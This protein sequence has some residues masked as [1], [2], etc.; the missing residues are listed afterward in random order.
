MMPARAAP[1]RGVARMAQSLLLDAGGDKPEVVRSLCRTRQDERKYVVAPSLGRTKSH[2]R[3]PHALRPR[4]TMG[5]S[6]GLFAPWAARDCGLSLMA[7][8]QVGRVGVD[9]H[10]AAR[11]IWEAARAEILTRSAMK[12]LG[13]ATQEFFNGNELTPLDLGVRG[14]QFVLVRGA[15]NK[16]LIGTA[17]NDGHDGP[18]GKRYSPNAI[19]PLTTVPVATCMGQWHSSIGARATC[20]GLTGELTGMLQQGAT[21]RMRPCTA[22]GAWQQR[23]RVGRHVR[24][25]LA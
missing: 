3:R 13:K 5:S 25:R 4:R 15:K 6:R 18:L 16:G 1:A 12:L 22:R 14:D 23:V 11:R 21:R 17:G 20:C 9:R 7:G 8:N 10:A 2:A 24:H 19:L